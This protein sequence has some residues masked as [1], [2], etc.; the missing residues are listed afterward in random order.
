MAAEYSD[1]RVIGAPHFPRVP[2]DL[3]ATQFPNLAAKFAVACG[4][5]TR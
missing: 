1:H 3:T 5:T 2:P 4:G